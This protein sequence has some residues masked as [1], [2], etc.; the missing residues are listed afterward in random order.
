MIVFYISFKDKE[1]SEGVTQ[2]NTKK[3][4]LVEQEENDQAE[5]QNCSKRRKQKPTKG[6]ITIDSD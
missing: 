4:Q 2:T 5:E 1:T 3:R 6:I